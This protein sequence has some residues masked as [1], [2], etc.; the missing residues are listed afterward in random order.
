[1]ITNIYGNP[2]TS[3]AFEIKVAAIIHQHD[4]C[5]GIMTTAQ[6]RARGI[7]SPAVPRAWLSRQREYWRMTALSDIARLPEH[8][9]RNDLAQMRGTGNAH[10][11]VTRVERG[12]YIRLVVKGAAGCTPNTYTMTDKG[13]AELARLVAS[14]DDAP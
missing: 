12:G 10:N 8:F 11:A 3:T 7:G 6:R 2:I 13:R 5:K 4:D 1:M 14:Q 9:T